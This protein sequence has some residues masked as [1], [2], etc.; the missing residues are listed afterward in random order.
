M[1]K[2]DLIVNKKDFL[3]YMFSGEDDCVYFT[4]NIINSLKEGKS[5]TVDMEYILSTASTIS[6]SCIVNEKEVL[7]DDNYLG[8]E[9]HLETECLKDFNLIWKWFVELK[10]KASELME[11]LNETNKLF[12]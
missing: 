1:A 6:L 2:T 4:E 8:D 9:C 3:E 5:I 10:I 11:K 7:E 12:G